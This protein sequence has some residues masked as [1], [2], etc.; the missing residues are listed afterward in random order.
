MIITD[1]ET[2]RAWHTDADGIALAHRDSIRSIGARFYPPDVV[3]AWQAGLAGEVYRRAMDAGEVFFVATSSVDQQPLMLGFAS[4][5]CIKGSTHGASVYVRGSAA[6]RGVGSA[7]FAL[8]E[9]HAL[10]RGASSLQIE[11][12]LAGVEFYRAHG[13]SE[14]GRGETRLLSGR[15]IECVFMSKSL[16]A[17]GR[18]R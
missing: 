7:L 4:E 18:S 1:F 6:R 11:S 3:D 5:F 2:R 17:A 8:A 16:Q 10:A 15:P 13:F 14:I 9:G 12:S